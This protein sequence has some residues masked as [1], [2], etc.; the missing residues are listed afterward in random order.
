MI[1]ALILKFTTT[2]NNG[3]IDDIL[4]LLVLLKTWKHIH[5]FLRSHSNV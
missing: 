1:P 3:K 5:S 2:E 4:A